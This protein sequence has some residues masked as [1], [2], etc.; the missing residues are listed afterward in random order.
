MKAPENLVKAVERLNPQAILLLD[1]N[2][3]MD[4]PRLGSYEVAGA[5]PFLLIIPR[6]V[7][8]ELS[9]LTMHRDQ[10]K[11]K[12][13]KGARD[14]LIGLYRRGDPTVGIDVGN[15]VYVVSAIA[16]PAAL[17]DDRSLEDD[18]IWRYLGQ[19]DAA[20]V[21]LASACVEDLVKTNTV[22]VTQDKNLT[23]VAMALGLRV[24]K[25]PNLR[26]PEELGKLLGDDS[27]GG[28]ADIE[29]AFASFLET[30]A[31]RRVS[32]S[33]TLEE[34]RSRGD[35]L[36]AQGTGRLNYSDENHPFRWMYPYKNAEKS[37]DLGSLFDMIVNTESMPIENLDFLGENE[38]GIP[39]P[40][41]RFACSMLESAGWADL[42]FRITSGWFARTGEARPFQ[43][44]WAWQ[45]GS[46]CLQSPLARVRL[47]FIYMEAVYW[48]FYFGLGRLPDAPAS[49]YEDI[50]DP[51]F[52]YR[53]NCEE[54][55][56]FA[57]DDYDRWFDN[58]TRAYIE[59]F[60]VYRE[61]ADREGKMIVKGGLVPEGGA[62]MSFDRVVGEPVEEPESSLKWLLEVAL[63]SWS[64]GQT[65]K[66]EFT[67]SPYSL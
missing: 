5:G 31:E 18:Q 24:C 58:F 44:G 20:L 13:A 64:I 30:D 55:M 7:S 66:D 54:L 32:I 46:Y 19:V 61:L 29:A 2:T 25:L 21:R 9:V 8:N 49:G 39:E 56:K 23:L 10:D 16:P 15:S 41:R 47:A 22:L 33:M 11:K 48:G 50:E 45:E 62:R 6:V 27:S 65:R 1:T 42:L 40:V 67:Y 59:A 26:S 34:I 63:N 4:N 36:I 3:L 38:E 57:A 51:Y 14:R 52:E 28:V 35:Y 43:F 17:P 12:K 53:A 60:E 37:Q